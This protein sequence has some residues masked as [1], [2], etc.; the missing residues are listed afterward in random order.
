[1][2]HENSNSANSAV[3]MTNNTRLYGSDT[4]TYM[5]RSHGC[6]RRNE[7]VLLGDNLYLSLHSFQDEGLEYNPRYAKEF[8]EG[9]ITP[10]PGYKPVDTADTEY[11]QMLFCRNETDRHP[12]YVHCCTTNERVYD[13]IDG[14]LLLSDLIYLVNFHAQS[15]GITWIDL[16]LLTC[17]GPCNND[18]LL[19][20][21]VLVEYNKYQGPRI[22]RGHRRYPHTRKCTIAGRAGTLAHVLFSNGQKTYYPMI[23][24]R[25][26]NRSTGEWLKVTRDNKGSLGSA[27]FM[28]TIDIGSF[29]KYYLDGDQLFVVD[30]FDLSREDF[31]FIRKTTDPYV[32][33]YVRPTDVVHYRIVDMEDDMD[34]W[35]DYY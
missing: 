13:F 32:T 17:H 14:D 22:T 8:C 31:M 33:L 2:T 11:F 9:R 16:N 3:S 6:Y 19:R 30:D 27:V 28:G 20:S 23:G 18:P 26:L 24:D 4:F 25:L 29:V 12:C 15:H 35:F 5:V 10:H 21:R 1:M 7:K 34:K